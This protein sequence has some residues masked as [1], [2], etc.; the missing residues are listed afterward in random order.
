MLLLKFS[1]NPKKIIKKDKYISVLNKVDLIKIN[2]KDLGQTIPISVTN[3][4]GI[5]L[6]ISRI[7]KTIKNYFPS[8]SKTIPTHIRYKIGV[9]KIIQ[10][11]NSAKDINLFEAPELVVEELKRCRY[12][13]RKRKLLLK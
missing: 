5:D 11:L 9:E 12:N 6:L 13:A 1:L 4:I 2:K 7:E 3:N 8:I 10:S